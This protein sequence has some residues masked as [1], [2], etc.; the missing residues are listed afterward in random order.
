[1][2]LLLALT[3][4][5]NAQRV[6]GVHGIGPR[7]GF[8]IDPDQV[9]FGGHLD[10]GDL[11]PQ[12]MMVPNVEVGFGDDL[13]VVAAMM[14]LNYRF[15]SEWG[16]WNPYLGGGIGPIF[17]N[18]DFGRDNTE[19]GVTVQGG[20]ARSMVSESGFMFMEFK[21]GLVEPPDVKLSVGWMF[22]S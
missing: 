22:G 18:S 9:H 7:A 14:D 11:A 17:Y 21:V 10:L 12:L 6:F 16:S 4:S 15:R 13:T 19:L 8:S 3:T 5:A 2:A 1:M 20:L